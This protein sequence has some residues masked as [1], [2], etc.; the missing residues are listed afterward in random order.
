MNIYTRG[1]LA[2]VANNEKPPQLSPTHGR[3]NPI[4]KTESQLARVVLLFCPDSINQRLA[5]LGGSGTDLSILCICIFLK[6]SRARCHHANA[7][8]S[9]TKTT[10][11][12]RHRRTADARTG[13]GS[14][15]GRGLRGLSLRP[16]HSSLT[17]ARHG[18]PG[19]RC[20]C[21]RPRGRRGAVVRHVCLDEVA[22]SEGRAQRQLAGQHGG[23]DDAG[24]EAC[25][26]A[27]CDGVG[28][29][30]AEHVEHGGLGL[31]DGAA[32][33]GA[34]FDG[35]HGDGDLEGAAEAGSC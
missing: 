29:A 25:V 13:G 5:L 32:A 20:R 26:L 30:H 23:G 31:E 3:R 33:Q 15:G 22:R 24:E 27:G 9:F 6:L 12:K 4:K 2:T 18:Q 28:A 17:Q 16:V 19:R 14:G 35:G 8:L 7:L 34:D 10:P 11:S 1:G 21:A